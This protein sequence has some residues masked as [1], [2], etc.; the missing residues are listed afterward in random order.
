METELGKFSG[1]LGRLNNPRLLIVE[2]C[3]NTIF[4]MSHYTGLDGQKAAVKDFI[5]V[6]RMAFLSDVN[7]LTGNEYRWVGGGVPK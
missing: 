6:I 4:A 5:D 2:D 7:Q 3:P 1:K